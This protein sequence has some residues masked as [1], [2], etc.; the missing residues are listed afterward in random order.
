[1]ML[2]EDA[3][4]SKFSARSGDDLSIGGAHVEQLIY[5]FYKNRMYVVRI[6]TK[7]FSNSRAL[8]EVLRQAYGSAS[9]PN[10][11]MEKYYWNG[12]K[13]TVTYDENSIT[14]DGT[15]WFFSEPLTAERKAD[16]KAKAKKGAGGL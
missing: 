8:L 11:F 2:K 14:H 1:M 5:G 7:G 15:V 10:Q 13:V 4:N 16:E 9:K 6:T 3:G 12:S